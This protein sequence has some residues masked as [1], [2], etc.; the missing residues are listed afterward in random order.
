MFAQRHAKE[1]VGGRVELGFMLFG[2]LHTDS[3]SE[4]TT[5]SSQMETQNKQGAWLQDSLHFLFVQQGRQSQ[6]E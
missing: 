4:F 1:P 2:E 6:G 5:C 3:Y